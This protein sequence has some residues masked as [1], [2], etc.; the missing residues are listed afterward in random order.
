MTLTADTVGLYAETLVRQ[1]AASGLVLDYSPES[2]ATLDGLLSGSD[3][4]YDAASQT[5]RS[6]VIFYAGCY[7]GEVFVRTLQAHWQLAEHWSE[8]RVVVAQQ[9]VVI[10]L[11]PFLKLSQR[12]TEGEEGNRLLAYYEGLLEHLGRRGV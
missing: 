12:L 2:L 8:A 6:L 4:A 1:A 10:Q 11:D 3:P 9:D 5:Q 7:L